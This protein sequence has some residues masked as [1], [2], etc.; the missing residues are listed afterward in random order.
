VIQAWAFFLSADLFIATLAKLEAFGVAG[1]AVIELAAIRWWERSQPG[2]ALA[3]V[4]DALII[5]STPAA[6]SS[7]PARVVPNHG[8]DLRVWRG[9]Q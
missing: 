4:R 8:P 9:W 1:Y 2:P 7:I 6:S 5:S 3:A